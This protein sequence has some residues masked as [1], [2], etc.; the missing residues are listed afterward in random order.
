MKTFHTILTMLGLMV[1]MLGIPLDSEGDLSPD[2][3]FF[4]KTAVRNISGTVYDSSGPLPGATVVV[5]GTSRGTQTD[6]D[7]KFTLQ[8][9]T[10]ETLVVNYI[11]YKTRE[12]KIGSSA[13][14]HIVL[15]EDAQALEEVVV[16]SM[17]YK[18]RGVSSSPTRAELRRQK[19]NATQA[20]I[21]RQLQGQAAGVQIV[22]PGVAQ[23]Q[24]VKGID[25]QTYRAG[26]Q[27][28]YI[29]D[30]VPIRKELNHVVNQLDPARI[31]KMNVYNGAEG[32]KRFGQEARH[33]CIVITT[34]QGNYRV[35]NDEAYARILENPFKRVYLS[36]LS[37]FSIDVDRASYSNI[38]R[39]INNGEQI[40][41]DA[42]KIEEMINYF[43]YD[44][45]QP[46]GEHPFSIHSDL[47]VTPWNR[48]TR[49][50]R[51]GL[52]GKAYEQEEL[53]PSNLTFLIDVSGS[54]NASNKLPLLKSAFKLLVNQLRRQDKVAIVVYAGAAGTVLP[55][56]RGDR[57]EEI[58]RA[59]DGL[60][61][62]GSTAGG[63]GIELAY[64]LAESHFAK[65]GNNRVILATDGDFNVGAS[66]D[67]AME[68]L[69]VE[70]RKS[71][72]FLSVL[73]F[74][75]GNYKD[76]KL[77]TLADKG[78]GNHAYI[79]TMQ[80]AQK[81]FGKEFG[82][83]LY[84]IAKDVKIQVEFNPG[85]V[86][87]YRL[88]GYENR[89]LADEDFMD[90]TKDAGELGSNHSVTALYEII[91][92]GTESPYLKPVLGLSYTRQT[93]SSEASGDSWFTVRF[94]YKKP[95]GEKSIEM[96]HRHEAQPA[97]MQADFSFTA[98]LALFGMHLRNS[99]FTNGS[100]L[101]TVLALAR[102]GK[103]KDPEGY[104][105]EFIRLVK[106][107]GGRNPNAFASE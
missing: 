102:E 25:G 81:V 31:D 22:A 62:G 83:T 26:K 82:G 78:N 14:I 21:A 47:A 5:K 19:L 48:D 92:V 53:P 72:V 90:D 30:G 70:K 4:N 95:D 20:D 37:T 89:L 56:T 67:R 51:I 97:Q 15:E 60:Q 42:V 33:G 101:D 76:S 85:L 3:P 28:L 63:A 106:T 65:N 36:P 59:L 105:G 41:V 40:P 50:V 96:V 98:S 66:S 77:E 100:D 64:K 88:V 43:T 7:G 2:I 71:G 8:A 46:K 61:A 73:G 18:V 35:E 57:K 99:A 93:S 55:P 86:Q 107:Y 16:T 87:A 24:E 45:K 13:N 1:G 34:V 79:D 69:I 103:G 94:R 29:V 74:G 104:R 12:V 49:L 58:L 52:Q 38:R 27:P 68:D 11:G 23:D 6:F 75:M 39:M 17:G 9:E 80:E 44:Y 10:G 32:R 91:P 84:T 54:M